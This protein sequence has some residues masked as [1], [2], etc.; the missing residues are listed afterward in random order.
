MENIRSLIE[1]I[2]SIQREQIIDILIG[3]LIFILFKSLSKS[4]AYITIKIFKPKIK[5]K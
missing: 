1:T 5:K 3:I 2:K 4:L